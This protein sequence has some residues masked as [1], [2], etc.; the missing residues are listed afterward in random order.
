MK[1]ETFHFALERGIAT[2]T[3]DREARLNSLTFDVYKE[4]A[5]CF[6]RLDGD[7]QIRAVVITGRGRGFCSGGDQDDIIKHLLGK[8][9]PALRA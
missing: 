6:E 3:L 8:D 1:A 7:P 4:L 5:E 2:I 9:T